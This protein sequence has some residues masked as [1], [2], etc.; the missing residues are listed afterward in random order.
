MVLNGVK[1]K[2]DFFIT[3]ISIDTFFLIWYTPFMYQLFYYLYLLP[4]RGFILNSIEEKYATPQLFLKVIIM[5]IFI[6]F[7]ANGI[8]WFSLDRSMSEQQLI[9]K[10][11]EFD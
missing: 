7:S 10:T 6:S 2:N 1:V 8:S 3:R 4:F 5:E 9:T 11:G